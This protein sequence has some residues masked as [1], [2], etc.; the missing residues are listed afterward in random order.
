LTDKKPFI[1]FAPGCHSGGGLVLI[2]LL[3]SSI[4]KN[5]TLHVFLDTRALNLIDIP[6]FAKV[7]W[8]K[9]SISSRIYAE[10]KL[11]LLSKKNKII[12]IF[13]SLPPLFPIRGKRIMYHQN[14]ILLYK[15]TF[16][17]FPITK[18]IKNII[19]RM[20]SYF[21]HNHIDEFIVQTPTMKKYLK[22]CY[23][24]KT[25]VKIIPF[26]E[27][28]IHPKLPDHR[29]GFI[30]VADGSEHKN[31]H[32]LLNAWSL[33][34]KKNI[35]PRLFLTL[36]KNDKSLLSKIDYLKRNEGLE[37]H[38]KHSMKH[39]EIIDFY[40]NFEA[41]IY[42]SLSESLG[43]PLLECSS[44]GLPIISS[45]LDYVRDICDPVETFDPKS[46]TSIMRAVLRF[47]KKPETKIKIY[48][49][50]EFLKEIGVK[51]E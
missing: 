16:N 34:G 14:L 43:L 47:M 33:L 50:T 35:K 32:N 48:S 20:Y 25:K 6:Y 30:Y 51:H 29:D 38:N 49:G 11:F 40:K 24:E 4:T 45:E 1:L 46:T 39:D 8:V 19:K 15:S 5:T 13:N 26:I 21:F 2:K 28:M 12:L 10:W 7:Y 36:D 9:P 42:P 17:I 23:G 44:I 31:H 3:L 27:Y 18:E 22:N 41:L 37:I